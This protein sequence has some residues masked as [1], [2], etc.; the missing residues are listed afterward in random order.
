MLDYINNQIKKAKE[1]GLNNIT[2][3]S[4]I[5]FETPSNHSSTLAI[6][7]NL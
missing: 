7:W 4:E 6:K 5:I 3:T 2:L 1:Q